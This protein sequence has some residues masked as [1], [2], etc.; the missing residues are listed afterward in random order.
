LSH[1]PAFF[2]FSYFSDRVSYFCPEP[3]SDWDPPTYN[4]PGS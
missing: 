3:A 2:A 1:A 4:F